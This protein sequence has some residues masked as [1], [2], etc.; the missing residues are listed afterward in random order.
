MRQA[1]PLD[2]KIKFSL[3][4]IEQWYREFEGKVYISFSGGKDSTVLLHIVRSKFPDVEAVFADTGLEY[5]EIRSFVKTIDNVTWVK[6]KMPFNKVI[7]KYG[8]PIV[9]KE[10]AKSIHDIRN[11]KSDYLRNKRIN[12]VSCNKSGKNYSKQKTGKIAE[13]W[14]PLIDAPFKISDR[15]CNVMKKAPLAKYENKTKKKPFIGSMACE[16]NNRLRVYLNT[17]CNAFDA[18]KPKST[19]LAFWSEEDIWSYIKKYDVSY[20]KIYD[21]GY[22][23]TGCMF[24]MFGLQYEPSDLF[25]KNRF[26]IMKETHPKQYKYCV[27][28]LG[29]GRVL[30]FMNISYT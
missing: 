18:K 26:Q 13:K 1:M 16:S 20:S 19:P 28:K 17:G 22:K 9:S 12:G 11:T 4:R 21:M 6:P 8:Y 25:R 14:K 30:D 23:R 24:C 27:E 29:C 3:S 2:L 15:C 7:E 5:P 10:V